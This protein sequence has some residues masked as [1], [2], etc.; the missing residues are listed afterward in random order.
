VQAHPSNSTYRYHLAMAL[1]QNGDRS[2]A[3][4]EANAALQLNP[5]QKEAEEIR[6]FLV[7]T[8]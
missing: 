1:L 6:Q 5:P 3:R 4:R 2:G 7:A 8:Q